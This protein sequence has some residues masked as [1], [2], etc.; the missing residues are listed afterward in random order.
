MFLLIRDLEK[1]GPA[2]GGGWKDYSK[3]KG[4]I[5]DKRHCHLSKERPTY[6]CMLLGSYRQ[7]TKNY[8]GVLC[9]Q[10][11]KSTVLIE[12]PK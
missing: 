4:M 12:Q 5:G 7:R 10:S 1:N 2:T 6:V 8:G 9:R 11:Q 3:L